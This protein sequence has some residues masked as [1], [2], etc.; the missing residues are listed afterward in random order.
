VEM[1]SLG[2]LVT[3]FVD[4]AYVATHG[5]SSVGFPWRVTRGRSMSASATASLRRISA[6]VRLSVCTRDPVPIEGSSDVGV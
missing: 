6:L 3:T 2:V 4:I 5:K 1:P